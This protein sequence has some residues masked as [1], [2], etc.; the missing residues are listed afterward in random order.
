M[1]TKFDLITELYKRQIKEITSDSVAW[2]AFLHSA[3]YQ[4]KYPF[5]DQVLIHAQRPLA[6][7][8]ADYDTWHIPSLNRRLHRGTKGIALI[9]EQNGRSRLSYVYDVKD[10]YSIDDTPFNLWQVKPEQTDELIE[11]LENRFGEI[12][13][14]DRFVSVITSA[15]INIGQDNITDYVQEMMYAKEGSFLEELDE[16]NVRSRLYYTVAASVT[17]SVLTRLG[18]DADEYIG[19][20]AF[21]WVHEFNTPETVNI[22]GTATADMSALCLR[23]IERTVK[24]LEKREQRENRTFDEN[25]ETVYNGGGNKENDIGGNSYG[26]DLHD[27][28]GR[29]NVPELDLADGG[30]FTD[31]QVRTDAVGVYE[32][33]PQRNAYDDGDR[34]EVE[35][36]SVR[37]RPSGEQADLGEYRE[38]GDEPWGNGADESGRSD[39]MGGDDEQSQTLGGGGSDDNADIRLSEETELPMPDIDTIKAALR[40]GDFLRQSKQNIVSFLRS[41]KEYNKK[42]DYVK[43]A[44]EMLTFIEFNRKETA[45]HIGYRAE[46]DGLVIYQGNYLTRTHETKF[47]WAVVMELIEVLIKDRDYLD[48]PKEGQQLSMLDMEYGTP[49]A[50]LPSAPETERPLRISQEV[51]DEFLRLGGCTKESTLRIYGFYRKA[52]DQAETVEFLKQEYKTDSVGIIVDNRK[53]AAMWN[54]DGVRI[55]TGERVSDI[56]SAF[57]TWEMVD[58][59][60]RELLEAGQYISQSEAERAVDVWEHYVAKRIDNLYFDHYR[61]IPLE[62][63][64]YVSWRRG[65]DKDVEFY[66]EMIN[67]PDEYPKIVKELKD[68]LPRMKTYLPDHRLIYSPEYCLNIAERELREPIDFPEANPYVLPPKQFVTQDMID[69]ALVRRGSGVENGKLRIYSYFCKH[70]NLQDRAN[71]L[72]HEYGLGGSYNDRGDISSD[73][74]G[75]AICGGLMKQ[76][77]QGVLLKWT[78]VAK[79]IDELIRQNKYLSAEEI[80]QLDRYEKHELARNIVSFYSNKNREN[81]MLFSGD[82]VMDYSG[83]VKEIE[84]KLEH[85]DIVERIK[86]DMIRL[87]AQMEKTNTPQYRYDQ[88]AV[89]SVIKFADGN[90]NLFPN[91]VYRRKRSIKRDEPQIEEERTVEETPVKSSEAPVSEYDF[92]LGTTVYIGKTECEITTITAERVELFD[93]TLIPLEMDYETFIRRI[94]EN[95]LNDHLKKPQEQ[96][97]PKAEAEQITVKAEEREYPTSIWERYKMAKEESPNHI[98]MVRVGDFY[99]FFEDDAVTASDLLELTLTGRTVPERASRIPMCGIP[100]HKAKEYSQKLLDAGH[101]IS[102]CENDGITPIVTLAPQ[103]IPQ[104]SELEKAKEYIIDFYEREFGGSEE[105]FSNL[106]EIPLAHTTIEDEKYI[107]QVNVN[108]VDFKVEKYLGGELVEVSKYDTLKEL[109]EAELSCLEF[110]EL[111]SVSDESIEKHK[112]EH[113]FKAPDFTKEDKPKMAA[114][115][116]S[117]RPDIPDE[118][119]HNYRITDDALGVGGAKEKFKRNMAAIRLLHEL[120]AQNRLAT[121]AE[122]EIL[123]Q[124]TGWGGLQEAFEENND[125]WASEFKE[126]YENLSPEEYRAASESVM[127]AFYTPPVVIRAMYEALENMGFKRGNILEPACGIGNFMGMIPDSMS[128]SKIYGVELDS[129]SGRIARQLYQKNGIT[130]DGFENTQFP[131]S[132]FDVAIGNVPFNDFKVVDKKFD[133]YN[134]LIHDYFF[135]KT[136]DK[137]RPNGVIAFITSKGTMDKQNPSVRRYLAERADL[138]GAIRLPEGTFWDNAGTKAVTDIIFLQK[139]DRVIETEADWVH[140]G[141]DENGIE[142]NQY[143]IDNPDMILG[144]MGTRSGQFGIE[145]TCRPFEGQELSDLLSNAVANLHAEMQEVEREELTGE[146]DNFIAADPTVKNYSFTLVK[147]KVYYRQNS[148]MKPVETSVT[149]ENRIKGMIAIRDTVRELIDAQINDYSDEAIERLQ[150]R[151]NSQYDAFIKKYGL[152]NSRANASVFCDDSSYFLLCSLEILDENKDLKAKADMFSKRTI[153]PQK[154]VDRVDT[155]SEALAVSIGERAFVDMDYMCELTGKSEE[156]IYADLK[157]VIFLNP[158]HSDMMRQPKYLPADEY[159]SGDVRAKLRVARKS[160]ELNPDDYAI[161]VEALE[162]VQPKDLTATEISV[163]LGTTWI[164]QEYVEQFVHELLETPYRLRYRIRVKYIPELAEWTISEKTS[165][166]GSVKST[167][168]YGTSRINAYQI[169]EQTL[170]LKSV[171]VMDYVDDGHGNMKPVLNKEETTIAQGK[172]EQIKRAFEEWI[173]KDQARREQLCEIYNEKFNSVRPREYDGS[174]IQFFGM[175][176]EIKLRKHQKDA[177]ARIMYGGNSLLAHVVGA[178]KTFTMVAAAQESKRLGLCHKSMIVVPNHLIEQWAS[179]YLQ[180]YPSANILVATKKDFEARNRK[181][182]CARIATGDYDAVI[183]GHSQFEKIPVSVERQIRTLEKEIDSIMLSISRLQMDKGERIT[184]KRFQKTKKQLETKL[185]KLN[186]QSR[187]DDVVTFEELGVDRVFIDEAHYYK[188]LAAYTKMRNVAGISQTEAQKSSDLYMKCRYLDELTGGKGV[189]F[190]TGTPISNTMVEFYTMQKYL[191]YDELAKRGMEHFDAWASTYGETVTAIEVSP[192]AQGYRPKTR[193][194]RFNNIPELIAMFK[195]VADIQTADMLN[196]PVPKANFHIVKAKPSDI[197]KQMVQSFAERAEKIHN[198]LVKSDE[199][200]MLLVTN[201]GRKAALDQR[202]LNPMLPDFEGSKINMCVQNVYDIW[203][204]NADKRSAQLVF[205]DLS[206]PKNDGSFNVYDDIRIKLIKMGIPAEEIAFIHSADTDT[207]KKELFAKVRQ[208]KVRVLLGSTLKMGAGT[209]VQ[210]RLIAIHDLDVPWRPADLEQRAG[211]IVRQGNTNPEV[212]IY[213]YITE[214]TFD[215]Y[216]YQLLESKQKFISQIMTSKSPVRSAEDVD[217][218]A[219][220]YAEIK[221]LASGNPK[222]MEKMQLDVDVAKLKLQKA[223]HLSERYALEDDLVKRY[224]QKIAETEALIRGVEADSA[225]VAAETKPD[226]NGFS[227]MVI[228]DKTYTDKGEA[229]KA[230]LEITDH[231]TN[232]EPIPLGEYRGLKMTIYFDGF[233]REFCIKL[234]GVLSYEIKLGKD[235]NGVI[236]R[237][238]NGLNSLPDK[239]KSLEADLTELHKQIENAKAEVAKPFPDEELLEEK[240]RRLDIL[241]AELNMDKRENELVDEVVE[242]DEEEHEMDA[243]ARDDDRDER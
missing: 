240:S 182:F 91:S 42:A 39:G 53:I 86:N 110:D 135:A 6:T 34:S 158:V 7:A 242:L 106:S 194:A 241:N 218:T 54:E 180:L 189:I 174:H 225:T 43:N 143:F 179:E 201:D 190:A 226:E 124:Y 224:P 100:I 20:E 227:P 59:R 99:E 93:G 62:Y 137:V 127:T 188:N 171:Q 65:R 103:D 148:V 75:L 69:R 207:K 197:Q 46:E 94:R 30:E 234:K 172:Q 138:I 18:Y 13:N 31:R 25:K 115:V 149:G 169:I 209:N 79:R 213:R 233:A 15:C 239:K 5:A 96:E 121:P 168:V 147:G 217:E 184:I 52:N 80:L 32:E 29:D 206:T 199:D 216:S 129:I 219:L 84:E 83:C 51:V 71:M 235:P 44:Y 211:R 157:G 98:V 4:Y 175:N 3:A 64:S 204:K 40:H 133:K 63:K 21:E 108:L 187:K 88:T 156:E 19:A 142:M 183:I 36:S 170:N 236:T 203:E 177:V 128:E 146:E 78:Q 60:I 120:E 2:R 81:I 191:E 50:P 176:P 61:N 151:L 28:R 49:D 92:K 165:D 56:T 107:V 167:S 141:K 8:C 17:Y 132:F 202:L 102:V 155:A 90:Y 70:S 196:L 215:A 208:G 123:A 9:R 220:S 26:I 212:D 145:T 238:N 67:N 85:A 185:K 101:S 58:K 109:N 47:S 144:E 153:K 237:L 104:T 150:A 77:N 119:K 89:E 230:I 181:K 221:A 136:L 74:K 161:N 160:A 223:A 166:R 214:G 116:Y 45:E 33:A 72:Q 193:F 87:F 24:A 222:I 68:N 232:K 41:E 162:K 130:I 125:R 118:E 198:G 205:C 126:L 16:D 154:T 66:K 95:K 48:A 229:G 173:W 57:L 186:D 1:L 134:F 140:L 164:P 12:R 22:L 131:D 113:S 10:T 114:P 38:T 35:S 97:K 200:N 111:V 76:S 192:D 210:E 122:Q 152:I 112:R 228:M 139:R 195:Q 117:F 37:D 105:D 163:K 23:E 11:A 27:E 55:S 243:P 231:I 82:P 159:L 178:G 14:K 73:S